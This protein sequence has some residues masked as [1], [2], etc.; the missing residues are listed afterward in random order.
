[1]IP[2]RLSRN[3]AN[4]IRREADYLRGR[5][6]M[7]ARNFALAIRSAKRM[8]QSFPE[9]GNRMHGLQVAGNR[10]LVAGDYLLEY[11]FDGVQIDV[12]SVRHGRMS[13]PSPDIDIDDDLG[14][15]VDDVSDTK[16]TP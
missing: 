5:N 1:M 14:D 10:T 16:P 15:D 13:T 6:P 3:A 12:V 11:A 9:A 2:I 7:A 4:Y 8:L